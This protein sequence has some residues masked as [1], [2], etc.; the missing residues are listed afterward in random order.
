MY[1]HFNILDLDDPNFAEM[2]FQDSRK[3]IIENDVFIK[4]TP[5]IK[6]L[7]LLLQEYPKNYDNCMKHIMTRKSAIFRP[8]EI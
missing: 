1:I 4:I 6:T 7:K 5:K 3:S 2:V 8:L